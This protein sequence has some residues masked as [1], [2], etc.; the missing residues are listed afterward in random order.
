M[1]QYCPPDYDASIVCRWV[2]KGQVE[3]NIT[4]HASIRSVVEIEALTGG[5]LVSVAE[6]SL[7]GHYIDL[8]IVSRGSLDHL[9]AKTGGVCSVLQQNSGLCTV[10]IFPQ[11]T[12]KK[13]HSFLLQFAPPLQTVKFY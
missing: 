10:T 1:F 3:F 4:A 9:V 8:P 5:M 7:G 13:G 12:S 6:R 11:G 2:H